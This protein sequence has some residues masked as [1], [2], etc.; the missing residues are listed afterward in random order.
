MREPLIAQVLIV[1]D[2]WEEQRALQ[3]AL[4]SLKVE[5]RSVHPHDVTQELI[6][7]ADLVLVD[8]RLEDW[9]QRDVVPSLAL[10]PLNG[11]ALAAV[12]RAHADDTKDQSPTA[13]AIYSGHV[14]DLSGGLPPDRREQ[15]IARTHNLEWVFSKAQA[16][17]NVPLDRQVTALAAAVRALP[18]TWPQTDVGEIQK[19]VGSLLALP[20]DDEEV[21]PVRAWL[22]VEAC[23]PPIHELVKA[24]HG[25]AFL[26]WM[27]HRILPYPCFLWDLHWTAARL[28]VTC[29]SL[30]EALASDSELDQLL[31]PFRYR[32]ILADF[33][34][35]H[36]WRSGIES[37]VWQITDGNSFEPAA[38]HEA[39]A[40]I[41]VN[42][43]HPSG[44]VEP[45][46]VIDDNYRALDEP[47]AIEAAVRI[48][49][50]DWPPY[51]EQAWTTIQLARD[52]PM[53]GALVIDLDRD[54]IA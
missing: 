5:A 3:L 8:L 51:A 40:G 14:D 23:H 50:D 34:G 11:L 43:L 16:T 13:F 6:A 42:R 44:L 53:L 15:A 49:P 18:P 37:F 36:W 17:W 45:V 20:T 9:Q 31:E 7:A 41:G 21:W 19:V 39:L 30:R 25:L 10:R 33:L 1:D 27:L 12:L 48:Q 29:E 28:R 24:S 46:V 52:I 47:V 54:M 38:I 35:P 32:G 2:Q 22:D 4:R 26:R